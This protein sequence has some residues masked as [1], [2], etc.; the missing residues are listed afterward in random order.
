MDLV[1]D[2]Q[3]ELVHPRRSVSEETV[4][5]LVCRYDDVVSSQ[6][7]VRAVIVAGRDSDP[8]MLAARLLYRRILLELLE[9]L[10]RQRSQG[11]EI[12]RLAILLEKVFQ[13]ADLGHERLPARRRTRQDQVLAVEHPCRYRVLLWRVE[14]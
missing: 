9:L 1:R 7:G 6:P 8:E 5:L 12:D 14:L 11:S 3:R 10:T 4:R 13:N 2:D